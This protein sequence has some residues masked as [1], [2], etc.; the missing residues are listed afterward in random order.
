VPALHFRVEDRVILRSES[1]SGSAR[2][3]IL[4]ILRI[5][6]ADRKIADSDSSKQDDKTR[7]EVFA[8]LHFPMIPF[9]CKLSQSGPLMMARTSAPGALVQDSRFGMNYS[10]ADRDTRT[11][12]RQTRAAGI[13]CVIRLN[14]NRNKE[15]RKV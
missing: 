3:L 12:V 14:P 1:E 10:R 15:R 8:V 13:L 6:F 9:C 2:S 4:I 7:E 5:S 11:L